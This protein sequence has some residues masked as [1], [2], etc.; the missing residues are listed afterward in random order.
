M[1]ITIVI[2]KETRDSLKKI[3]QKGQTCDEIIKILISSWSESK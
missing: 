3:G 2:N 1:N